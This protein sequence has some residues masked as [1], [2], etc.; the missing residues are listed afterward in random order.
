MAGRSRTNATDDTRKACH[1]F[2]YIAMEDSEEK[3]PYGSR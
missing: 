1:R 3:V 2:S